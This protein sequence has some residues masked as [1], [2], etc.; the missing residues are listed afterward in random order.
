MKNG[1][2]KKGT[3]L[4]DGRG[5]KDREGMKLKKLRKGMLEGKGGK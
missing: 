4:K 3:I 2:D 5:G 1:R